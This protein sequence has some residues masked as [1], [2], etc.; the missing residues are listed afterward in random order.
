MSQSGILK[1]SGGGGG[2][3]T[4]VN[5]GA[6]ISITGTATDPI[7]NVNGTTDHAVQVGTG[8]TGLTSITVGTTGQVLRGATGANPAFGS[9][10]LTTDVTGVLPVANG[11][12]N[13]SSF[14]TTDGTIYYDGTRLVTTATGTANQV[15]TSNGAGVAPTYQSLSAAGAVT[16]VNAGTNISI[17]GTATAPIVNVAGTTNH[18]VLLGTGTTGVNSLAVG[19]S[20]TV[21]SG[22]T[23]TDPVFTATPT[24][25][26]ITIVNAPVAGTDGVN[27][28]YAD[29]LVAGITF[30]TAVYAATTANLN[31]TYANG[32]AGVGATLTNA[33][34]LALFTLDGTTPPI[35]SRILVKNQSTQA[36]NGIYTLTTIG[37]G[38]VAWVLT[39]ATDYD[40]ASEIHP[41]DLV[42][43]NNGTVNANTFW[44]QVDTVA[45]MGTDPIA[46]NEFF[47]GGASSFVTDSG[48]AVASSGAIT[49][50]GGANISTSGSGSTVTYNV[51]GTN[52][53]AVQVGKSGTGL[54]QLTVG[55]NGQVL[56]G[57]SAAD[58]VF[59][60][61]ASSDGSI[62]YATG[63]G[64]LGATVTQATTSQLGGATL[65]TNAETIAGTVTNK[66]VTPDD[67]KAKLGTQTNHAV[68][69]GAG[70][71]AAVTAVAT[72]ATSGVPLVSQG[73]AA[74]PAFGTAVV[75]GGGTG[76]TTFTAYSVIA[77]GTTATGAFQNVSGLGSSGNVLTSAGAGALPVWAAPAASSIS[78]T[79]DSGGA[80]TGAAFTFTG[81]TTGL[82]FSGASTTET[83]TGTLAV[84]NGGTGAATLT[85]VLTGNGTSAVTASTIT[86]Y[87][88][89]V[90]GASNAVASVA[91]SA[92]SGIPYISQ[93]SS[94]N[95]T[96]GT[97]VVAGGGTGVTSTTAYA[98]I[99]GGTTTTG[100]FQAADTNIGTSGFVLTSTGSSSIPTWQAVP[101]E[102]A[103]AVT[104]V[105]ASLVAGNGYI[106]NKAGL[107]TMTLPASGAIGDLIRI[108]N[109]NTAVG[110]RIAQ[111]ANQ[112]ILFGNA[113]TTVG[114]GGY[115][116][117]TAIGDSLEMV[118]VVSGA[119]TRWMVLNSQGNITLV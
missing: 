21:L 26:S 85:G 46:F 72:S 77:A 38:A 45:T 44:I 110:W 51:G 40:Q 49:M 102:L 64:T 60:T 56:V 84:K 76:N 53:H 8:T 30:K 79:G 97:A 71:T 75:A 117:A 111:N 43:V 67:L 32:A 68:L 92:T 19:A 62:T 33:G 73:A 93:G 11:G 81:G 35:N 107:L 29:S 25:T 13:A 18:S 17:T 31:A 108:C 83:L 61:L 59:A 82:T 103:W 14:A 80:L 3:V 100:A 91:P 94:S 116:E 104:T 34:A 1:T 106:A 88:T 52:N 39:R 95:P 119:S 5:A 114:V 65:A 47:G 50:A 37:S 105:N 57:S 4:S 10:N 54:T 96:F 23:G 2:T 41:G 86:Q 70:T 7:V 115:L 6:N 55:T 12:T 27:K 9:L 69:V 58:P 28:T 66:I 112:A 24:V 22:M 109:L 16:S 20:G 48:T 42:P 101:G 90:A 89:V 78:I 99:V 36:Q 98:P 118:C 63:A 15:L 113:T 87:G 74:D